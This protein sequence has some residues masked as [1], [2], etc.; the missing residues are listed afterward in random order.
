MC[1]SIDTLQDVL[2]NKI[3]AIDEIQ[4]TETLIALQNLIMRTIVP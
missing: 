4:S 1:R 3:Q 2:I